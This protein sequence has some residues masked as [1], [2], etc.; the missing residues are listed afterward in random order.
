MEEPWVEFIVGVNRQWIAVHRL[1]H[2]LS[3]P[4]CG[5][6]PS[7]YALTG[8]NTVSFFHGKE[9][10]SIWETWKCYPDAT[11]VFLALSSPVDGV[12]SDNSISA[13]ER[14]ICPMYGKTTSILNDC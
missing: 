2:S 8:C 13:I 4:E 10:R 5:A 14:F 7:W 12:L 3:L 1:A 6:F 9:K 11:E